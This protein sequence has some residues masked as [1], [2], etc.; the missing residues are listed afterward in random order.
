MQ[1]YESSSRTASDRIT[2]LTH[3]QSG[4]SEL[5]SAPEA[6]QPIAEALQQAR[7]ALSELTP[8]QVF[9]FRLIV[10]VNLWCTVVR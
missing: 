6:V 9:I 2:H 8:P 7:D 3:L 10:A 5:T 1:S 4:L